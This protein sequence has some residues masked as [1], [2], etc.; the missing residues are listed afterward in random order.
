[1]STGYR[2]GK[3]AEWKQRWEDGEP[4]SGVAMDKGKE[5]RFLDHTEG[6]QRMGRATQL[7][8]KT[9]S[10]QKLGHVLREYGGTMKVFLAAKRMELM[11]RAQR[12]P[13]SSHRE[14][15]ETHQT[16]G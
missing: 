2:H 9:I 11:R 6:E 10:K 12:T 15:Q 16:K 13:G 14:D 3:S 7:P 5:K 8:T 4:R 1:M